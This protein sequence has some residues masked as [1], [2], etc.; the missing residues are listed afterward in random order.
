LFADPRARAEL[1]PRALDEAFTFWSPLAPRTAFR[2]VH[3]L[4]PGHWL[5]A[6]RNSAPQIERYWEP[7][8]PPAGEE[9]HTDAR[10]AAANLHDLLLDAVQVRL[11]ADV[12]VATSLS[13]G[14]D[15]SVVTALARRCVRD[16]ET[17]SIAFRDAAFDETPFQDAMARHLGTRH[18]RV[19]CGYEDIGQAFPD[20]V[21]HAEVPVLRTSPVPLYLLSRLVRDR[22][23]KVFLTGEGADE[24]L[25]S[26]DIFKEAKVR[27]FWARQPD[28]TRRPALLPKL[29]PY[30]ASL[31]G[32]SRAYVESFF[33]Q[34]LTATA[35]A[36]YSHGLR[37]NTTARGKRFF[38][39]DL[40]AAVHADNQTLPID[41]LRLPP[42]MVFPPETRP[43]R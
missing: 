28:S 1:D 12:P 20:V 17:F 37:W 22:G 13:G 3:S 40:R 35:R 38:C 23:F 34:G 24:F 25:A 19:E 9:P 21:W 30:I 18:H 27:R 4:P 16:L 39:A 33:A 6:R 43:Q 32:R 5:R 10:E 14:L 26:Y 15:S 36:D 11:R 8:F 7:S 29:Y 41:R 2:G 42:G 31:S